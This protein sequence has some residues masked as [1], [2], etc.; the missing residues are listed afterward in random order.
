VGGLSLLLAIARRDD[1]GMVAAICLGS[2]FAV[3]GCEKLRHPDAA[4]GAIVGFRIT[5]SPRPGLGRLL[6]AAEVGIAIG[7][8]APAPYYVVGAGLAAIA[9]VTFWALVMAALRRGDEFA[10]HCLSASDDTPIS[11]QTAMRALAIGCMGVLLTVDAVFAAQTLSVDRWIV[12]L[13]IGS[14]LVAMF[15]LFSSVARLRRIARV[16]VT[17]I[18]W[19]DVRE[20]YYSRRV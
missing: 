12:D 2:V 7:L 9:G 17:G 13:V 5:A 3:A 6:G 4:A 16:A 20:M 19:V 1:V 10:C 11:R 15:L 8:L 14:A 18:N